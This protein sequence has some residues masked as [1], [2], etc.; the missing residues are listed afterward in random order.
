MSKLEQ[1][2]KRIKDAGPD[3]VKAAHIQYDYEPVGDLM[4]RYLNDGV[5]FVSC[6]A[7]EFSPDSEQRMF[8]IEF[9]PYRTAR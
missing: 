8:A 5:E 1:L 4:M 9:D 3:G 2:K 6:R 7:P